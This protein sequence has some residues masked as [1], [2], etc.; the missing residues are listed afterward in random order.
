MSRTI[1][2]LGLMLTSLSLIGGCAVG[3]TYHAPAPP[4]GA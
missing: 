1:R 2:R 3:P 4:A